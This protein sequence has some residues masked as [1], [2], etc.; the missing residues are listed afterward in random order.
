MVCT[1]D[2]L[3]YGVQMPLTDVV[4]YI[5]KFV[6]SNLDKESYSTLSKNIKNKDI[7]LIYN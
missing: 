5:L 4:K 6:K 2:I 7:I 3:V 1:G